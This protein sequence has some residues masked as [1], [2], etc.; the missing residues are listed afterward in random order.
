MLLLIVLLA[1]CQMPV[2]PRSPRQELKTSVWPTPTVEVST[3]P[4]ACSLKAG[5]RAHRLNV[6]G[7][8]RTYLVTV[9][10]N[11]VRQTSA[12]LIFVWHGF[13]SSAGTA[14]AI[15]EPNAYWP[16]AVVVAPQ[17]LRRTFEQF[18]AIEH[19]GWQI[20]SGE[21]EDRDLHF[22]DAM[23]RALK[24]DYCVDDRRIYSTGFSNGGFF[25]NVLG[26]RRDKLLAAIGP[27][28]GGGPFGPTC[29]APIS[30]MITH[31]TV[32]R[33]VPYKLAVES[34]QRWAKHNGCAEV[35]YPPKQGCLS[36][37]RCN[38]DVVICSFAMG[39]R[40]P[41]GTTARLVEFFKDR[42]RREK[43]L[44]SSD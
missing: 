40:W 1:G 23:L 38:A 6:D 21:L 43:R 25:S 27:V 42:R 14:T 17:G 33:V 13:G 3:S 22:F 41:K 36:A 44:P 2:P 35:G 5:Q 29:G 11:A 15:F 4:L 20:H 10:P 28:G 18:G 19:E 12:P 39:H 8:S 9:G 30:V 24:T 7:Q 37:E 16:E 26:C 34:Q 32:D 31:G